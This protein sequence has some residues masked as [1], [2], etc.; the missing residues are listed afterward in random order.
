MARHFVDTSALVKLYRNEPL[1]I[2]VQSCIRP[3][4]A[5]VLSGIANLEFQSAFFRLVRQNLIGQA[6]ASQR[7]AL[8]HKDLTN[9]VVIAITQPL[10]ESAEV[11]I[12]RFGISEGLRPADALQLACALE[13]NRQSPLDSVLTTDVVLARCSVASGLVVKP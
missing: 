5:L 12:G 8:L 6:D 1:S 7:V 3:N 4:D 2:A 9:Y 13:A 10:V 11:L